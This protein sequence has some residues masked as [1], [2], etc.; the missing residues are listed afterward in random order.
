MVG[1]NLGDAL[2]QFVQRDIERTAHV[3]AIEF[4]GLADIEHG[5][6][7]FI[8]QIGERGE[9]GDSVTAQ[10]GP[11]GQVADVAA[12]AAGEAID[13]D[14]GEFTLG[15]GDLL[16]SSPIKVSGAPHAYSQPR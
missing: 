9:F 13:A 6:T 4:A 11:V 2:G 7:V 8:E 3:A 14:A 10:L 12:G 1:G 15:V 16:V 5:D